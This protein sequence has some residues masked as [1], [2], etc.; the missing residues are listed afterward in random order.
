MLRRLVTNHIVHSNSLVL[1]PRAVDRPNSSVPRLQ[2]PL[3]RCNFFSFRCMSSRSKRFSPAYGNASIL[4]LETSR[5]AVT[6]LDAYARPSRDI[7]TEIVEE[8]E[9]SEN[10]CKICYPTP[11]LIVYLFFLPCSLFGDQAVHITL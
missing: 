4:W 9:L 10:K 2:A 1:K 8:R 6:L 7:A 11:P 3:I 5:F